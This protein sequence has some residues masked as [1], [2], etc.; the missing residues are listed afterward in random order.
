MT[1]NEI[2]EIIKEGNQYD[3]ED[4]FYPQLYDQARRQ[5]DNLLLNAIAESK[6]YLDTRLCQCY[7]CFMYL[8]HENATWAHE[9]SKR[10]RSCACSVILCEECGDLADR[11]KIKGLWVAS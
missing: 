2:L 6:E 5:P 8:P 3:Y 7:K 10:A 9:C 1:D 4:I 11:K